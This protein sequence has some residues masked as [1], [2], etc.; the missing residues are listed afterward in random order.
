MI[1]LLQCYPQYWH[2]TA[3]INWKFKIKLSQPVHAT[4]RL[5]KTNLPNLACWSK[6]H[7][8]QVTRKSLNRS[9]NRDYI[10]KIEM[11][12][13]RPM[14][15]V[16]CLTLIVAGHGSIYDN[17]IRVTLGLARST[18]SSGMFALFIAYPKMLATSQVKDMKMTIKQRRS[19]VFGWFNFEYLMRD[20]L[21]LDI[22]ICELK[23]G[24]S[25]HYTLYCSV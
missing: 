16:A 13:T 24:K 19:V 2:L 5:A 25:I 17:V 6:A 12:K 4:M 22:T 14:M 1:H 8:R 10:Q 3:M 15:P 7:A 9:C 11:A 18:P 23:I 21:E 20:L